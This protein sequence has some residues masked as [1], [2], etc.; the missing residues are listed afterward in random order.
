VVS[1]IAG[2]GPA[3]PL[4]ALPESAAH[5]TQAS[6]VLW[7]VVAVRPIWTTG[8]Q[9]VAKPDVEACTVLSRLRCLMPRPHTRLHR[10][11][12]TEMISPDG[13]R[14]RPDW[15]Q[16]HRGLPVLRDAG[17]RVVVGHLLG[18]GRSSPSRAP[19][20]PVSPG[21][22]NKTDI[23]NHTPSRDGIDGYL[24]DPVV[25]RWIH[26]APTAS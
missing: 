6:G 1:V 17:P 7:L 8:I 11:G 9:P 24:D 3:R 10:A 13:T 22:S 23:D 20:V 16:P 5:A 12:N 26:D 25:A 19:S 2:T 14:R 18:I 21:I 15:R 4:R